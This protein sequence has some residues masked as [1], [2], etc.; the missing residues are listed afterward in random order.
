MAESE[1]LLAALGCNRQSLAEM[2]AA[3]LA[4]S[5]AETLDGGAMDGQA[6]FEQKIAY[7]REQIA[8]NP[9]AMLANAPAILGAEPTA[10]AFLRLL[11]DAEQA[12]NNPAPA[13]E[14]LQLDVGYELPEHE[15]FPGYDPTEIT[16]D[17][18][19]TG[20]QETDLAGWGL[21]GVEAALFRLFNRKPDL[22]PFAN[23]SY[24][25][26]LPTQ[27][28]VSQVALFSDWGNGHYHARYIA[29]HIGR[30]APDCAI[31]LGDI[32]YTGREFE[33]AGSFA[34]ILERYITPTIPFYALNA[35]HEMDT[36]GIAYFNYLAQ[37]N[38]QNPALHP[39]ES[40]F[41]TLYNDRFQITAIDTA[42][43]KNGRFEDPAMLDWLRAS[44]EEGKAN[45]RVNIL[46]SQSEP[47]DRGDK[48]AKKLL[49]DVSSVKSMID[50]WFW[51]DQHFAAMYG[52]NSPD[53][54]FYGSCIGHGGFPYKRIKKREDFETPV[55][56]LLYAEQGMRFSIRD[57]RGANGFV[58]LT[59]NDDEI[60]IKFI[61]W[62]LRDRGEILLSHAGGEIDP[63]PVMVREPAEA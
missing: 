22:L 14:S 34:S 42:Y 11:E 21:T 39:Q 57:D 53:A 29:K 37:K 26:E 7:L 23:D 38:A 41:F 58:M 3:A 63:Q 36:H 47:Y 16:I 1:K 19:F 8:Q 18:N 35:N 54:P 43:H 2:R 33:V 46:L 49:K 10:E 9:Q 60:M 5:Q 6:E 59:L 30:L 24:R 51:G 13:L 52:P 27:D 20:Y 61:D 56:P 4:Q 55:A 28:G 15:Q 62:R 32:Y 50:L 40:S 45:D 17:P 44:L 12:I 48:K 25:Y 31:H